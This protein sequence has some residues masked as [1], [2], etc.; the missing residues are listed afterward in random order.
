MNSSEKH[1]GNHWDSSS[2]RLQLA[3]L[4]VTHFVGGQQI[5]HWCTDRARMFCVHSTDVPRKEHGRSVDT[6]RTFC[7]QS[8]DVLWTEHGRSVDRARTFRRQST[9]V[10][11]TEHRRFAARARMFRGQST[12]ILWLAAQ[13]FIKMHNRVTRHLSNLFKLLVMCTV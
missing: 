1:L 8:T 2:L 7:G 11:R 3:T 12:D 6:A 9:D 13:Q 5:I 10:A 4:Q